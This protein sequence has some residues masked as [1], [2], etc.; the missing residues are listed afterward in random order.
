M[1]LNKLTTATLLA[2]MLMT[3]APLAG[4]GGYD[5]YVKS[6]DTALGRVVVYRN[7]VAYFERRARTTTNRLSM[8]VPENK[9]NDFLKSL[10]VADAHTGETLPI[11]FPTRS[12][13]SGGKVAMTIQLP[14]AKHRDLVLSYITD[15]PAWKSTYRVM[16]DKKGKVKL[17]GWAIVDNTS[18]EDWRNVK[19]GVGSSSALSFRYDLRS[20]RRV[21]R[22]M[23]QSK[24]RFAI[25]PPTGGAVHRTV[26]GAGP[27]VMDLRD[28]E[29]P[30]PAGHPERE[31][32]IAARSKA[33]SS[34]SWWSSGE[35]KISK[36]KGDDKAK[37]STARYEMAK[38]QWRRSQT[39]ANSRVRKMAQKLS[40]ARGQITIEGYA[41]KGE[42]AP[43]DRALDR[44]N[45][46][47]NALIK[48]GIAPARIKVAAKGV[49]AGRG[50]GARV[51]TKALPRRK[52]PAVV[53]DEPVGESHFESN[54]PMTVAKGTSA[55]VSVVN[56]ATH[57]R[58]V[59]LYDPDARRGNR[60]FAF[61]SVRFDNPTDSTLDAG[62]MTVYGSGRFIGEGMA[63]PIPPKSKAIVPFA[64]DRQVRVERSADNRDD[65]AKLLDIKRGIIRA[66]VRHTRTTKYTVHNRSSRT[67]TLFVRHAVRKGWHLDSLKNNNKAPQKFEK[68]GETHLV[69]VTLAPG[70]QR[71][72]KVVEST[73]LERSVDLRSPVGVEMM[74]RHVALQAHNGK[75]GPFTA[76]LR[77]VIEEHTRIGHLGEAI[78]HLRQRNVEFRSRLDELHGQI[79]SLRLVRTGGTL[80]RHL[81]KKMKEMSNAVQR[82]T[83]EVVNMQ[84][85]LMLSRIRFDDGVSELALPSRRTAATPATSKRDKT[86]KNAAAGA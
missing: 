53:S 45:T 44:A 26:G 46:L 3:T 47:R 40:Q 49:V 22:K 85:Q 30:R 1:K 19:I 77:A 81:Q 62:P 13:S 14:N 73:P 4:C 12:R 79:I 17:Q 58:I 29:I 33:T 80:M 42:R 20:I 39:R 41:R 84:E 8:T 76:D 55:M 52:G 50:S 18:G 24:H 75:P 6:D 71:D 78:I 63:T 57:G 60:R 21:H 69:S 65:I 83:I 86:H 56:T 67:A 31:A 7:G 5:T 10:T 59:Y 36:G 43:R 25:A 28:E 82:T 37:A 38:R 23:L 2:A 16:V 74:R 35:D 11:S 27:M 48:Q 64:M 15:A 66:E 54:L 61:K 51:V 34:R 68:L 9:V 72:I 32:D 70:E